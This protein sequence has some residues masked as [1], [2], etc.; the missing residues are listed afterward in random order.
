MISEN[1]QVN[2]K[3]IIT[4]DLVSVPLELYCVMLTEQIQISKV[5]SNS[6]VMM[7]FQDFK[8]Y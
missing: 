1:K 6:D 8:N 2:V 4:I 7:L 5:Y 3:E